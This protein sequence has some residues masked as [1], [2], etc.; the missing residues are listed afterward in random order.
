MDEE[1]KYNIL[2]NSS[3]FDYDFY[4]MLYDI[5][6]WYSPLKL[7]EAYK[8]AIESVENL[9]HQGLIKIIKISYKEIEKD[10]FDVVSRED[11]STEDEWY[12]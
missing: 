7:F 6:T 10:M 4:Q 1:L 5:R 2:L 12:Y 8:I 11:I 3:D 9:I